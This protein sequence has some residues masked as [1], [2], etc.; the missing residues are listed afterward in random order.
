VERT[1]LSALSG[2]TSAVQS[3]ERIAF[4]PEG[5]TAPV[6][7]RKMEQILNLLVQTGDIGVAPAVI[8]A[9]ILKSRF[10]PG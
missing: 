3:S 8:A 7:H 5:K 6:M 1:I 9:K 10:R 2:K 4:P